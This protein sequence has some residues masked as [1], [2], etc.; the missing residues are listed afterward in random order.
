MAATQSRQHFL[1]PLAVPHLDRVGI[2]PYFHPLADQPG[3]HRVDVPLHGDGAARLHS[4]PQPA[5]RFLP[6]RRQR[7]QV[8]AFVDELL[9][10]RLIPSRAHV[11]QESH[12]GFLAG[13]VVAATQEQGLLHRPLEAMVALLDVAVLVTLAGVDRLRPDFIVSHQGAI[14][15]RE[16]LGAG[17]LHRQAH[18]VGAMLRRHA[19]QS[20]DRVLEARTEALEA[21]GEA[22]RD[23]LPVRVRQHE[24]VDQVR[25]R[26]TRDGHAQLGHVR[27]VGGTEPAGRMLLGEKHLLGRSVRCQPMLDVSL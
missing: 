26:L 22:E 12:V 7:M 13:K 6:L 15:L 17:G 11:V 5:K 25:E 23:V 8:L 20:P 3:R 27:E 4:H 18:A 19:A 21:L 16:L 24:V 9:R 1:L 2:H 14:A 10:S